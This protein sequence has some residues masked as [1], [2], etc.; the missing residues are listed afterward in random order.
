MN[1]T[2]IPYSSSIIY[3]IFFVVETPYHRGKF[4]L[5]LVLGEDYPNSP[6]KGYFLTKIYHPNVSN[7]GDICVNTLKK[8][9]SHDVTIKHILSVIRC[10]LIVPFPE[11][12]LNDEAGKLFM[13]SYEEFSKRARIMTEVHA[14]TL[15]TDNEENIHTTTTTT[16]GQGSGSSN[17]SSPANHSIAKTISSFSTSTSSSS[18]TAK[19]STNKENGSSTNNT[20]TS[21]STSNTPHSSSSDVHGTSD[22]G[23]IMNKKKDIKKK[24]LKRL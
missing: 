13:D 8:D 4:R 1:S 11:S 9:W 14:I 19:D 22:E 6:P 20:S 3:P 15:D 24:N 16:S 23:L 18:T 7:N 21:S 17:N 10:L 12:S 2:N 5:K